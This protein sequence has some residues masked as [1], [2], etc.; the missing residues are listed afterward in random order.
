MVVFCT[1]MAISV[2][3]Q[4]PAPSRYSDKGSCFCNWRFLCLANRTRMGTPNTDKTGVLLL[5]WAS[6]LIPFRIFTSSLKVLTQFP[7]L[8]ILQ[9]PLA[10]IL[11]WNGGKGTF[12]FSN[13]KWT[14]LMFGTSACALPPH[15]FAVKYVWNYQ[16]M[17]VLI[18]FAVY[19]DFSFLL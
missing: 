15:L 3:H 9:I 14:F 13:W 4:N 2:S 16:L 5:V 10:K 7:L 17:S 12:C 18:W 6:R 8:G 19:S 1:E 11:V